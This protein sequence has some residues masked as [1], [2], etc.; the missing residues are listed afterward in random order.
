MTAVWV[1]R[2][3]RCGRRGLWVV[4]RQGE[5]S[6]A[7]PWPGPTA[8]GTGRVVSEPSSGRKDYVS[9][10]QQQSMLADASRIAGRFSGIADVWQSPFATPNPTAVMAKSSVWFTAYPISMIP[11]PGHS[12]LGTLGDEN[13]WDVFAAIGINAVHTGPL[14]RA[15]GVFGRELTPS[16]DGHFDRISTQIDGV[17]G[18]EL[19]FRRLCEVAA[20]YGGIVIDDIVPG[21]TGKGPDF[22]LAEMKVGDYPGIYHMVEIPREDWHLLPEVPPGKDS[23]NLDAEAEDRLQRAGYIVGRL[24]RVIFQDPGIKDTNWS[25]TAPVT[26]PDGVERRW[27]YLHYFKDGQPSINWLDPTFA[28]VRLVIGDALHSLGHLG[29]GALRLDANGF[30]GIERSI[31]GDGPAWSEGH[32]LSEAANQLIAS[33]VRKV[34]GFTF[35]ELNLSI[36]DIKTTSERGADLSYDFV[37]RPAYAHAL[38]TGDTEFLRM[39]LSAA[40]QL[41]L[42]PISLVHALQNHDEMTYELVHFAIRHKD[43][44]FQFRGFELTGGELAVKIRNELI[45]R[46]TGEAAPYNAVFTTNGIAS[47]IATIIAGALGYTDLMNLSQIRIEKIKQAHLLLAMF[48]AWQPGVFALSGWDL[49]GMLTLERSKVSRLLASGD[50]R[51]IHRAAYDLMDYQPEATESPS[52]MPRGASLYGSLPEQL[53]DPNSFASRL[54]EVLAVRSRYRIS[55]SVQVDVPD[56]P[57]EAML[58]M[59]HL[60]DTGQPQVTVLNFSNRSIAGRVKSGHLAPGAAV[61]DMRTDQLIAEV[62]P[63]QTFAVSLEPYQGMALLTV[64]VDVAGPPSRRQLIDDERASGTDTV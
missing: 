17:F 60:L 20:A 31:D 51:W 49:C 40:L 29:A 3:R 47:T 15:G 58:V 1:R 61:I 12:F 39:T 36:D 35:Q 46:L 8:Y 59:V 44:I 14:K 41:G 22:R 6:Y 7:G 21:H 53:Q 37:N 24:Q 30:L 2:E 52:K 57:D 26:G 55:T 19:E 28:G 16:V 63:E 18:S 34:G 25:A 33:M 27:V 4:R 64:P 11:K 13:L 32:P 5:P 62:D 43:D 23:V 45:E 50:T 48:N 56:V 10:L 9:W 54:R 42:Q 38:A